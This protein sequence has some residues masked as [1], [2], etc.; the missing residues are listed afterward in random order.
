MKLCRNQVVNEIDSQVLQFLIRYAQFCGHRYEELIKF[1]R[2]PVEKHF[3][4]AL[5]VKIRVFPITLILHSPAGIQE[6]AENQ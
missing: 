2:S 5:H 3:E 6:G 4:Y 1:I